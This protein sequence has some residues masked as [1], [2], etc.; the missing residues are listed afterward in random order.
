MLTR[1]DQIKRA[2]EISLGVS[3]MCAKLSQDEKDEILSIQRPQSSVYRFSKASKLSKGN[4]RISG[5]SINNRKTT[6]NTPNSLRSTKSLKS[7]TWSV[8]FVFYFIIF[9]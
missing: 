4:S 6:A 7:V 2:I 3:V 8:F 9:M 1:P 5:K